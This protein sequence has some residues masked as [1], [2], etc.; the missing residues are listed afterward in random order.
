MWMD[1]YLKGV[2]NG[3]DRLPSVISETSDY[4]GPVGFKKGMPRTRNVELIAQQAFISSDYEWKLLPSE[5]VF[6]PGVAPGVAEFP[7]AGINTETHMNHHARSHHDWWWFETPALERDVRIFGAPKV[8]LWSTVYRKW[9][10][11]TPVL[12]DVDPAAH[13][14]VGNQHTTYCDPEQVQNDENQCIEPVVGVTRGFLDSRYR[15]GLH[16]EVDVTPGKSFGSKIVM[17]PQDYVFRKGHV[18]GLQI[19]SE[20]L[21]W[22][23]PKPPPGCDS[24]DPGSFNP[25][26]ATP[27]AQCAFFRIDWD[28]SQTRLVL[29]VV[30]APKDPMDL[31]DLAGHGGHG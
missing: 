4:E 13:L 31:F 23:V 18:I 10:T 9:I 25:N 17:K 11:I 1:H 20:I 26:N 27:Q 7:S 2:D 5:P 28:K 24:V 29:P 19:A 30:N 22:H 8:E 12:V 15:N 3:I 21:E 14:V 6:F 16:K